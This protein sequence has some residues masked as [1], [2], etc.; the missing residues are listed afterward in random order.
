M[1]DFMA[2]VETIRE[3]LEDYDRE[4]ADLIRPIAL[5]YDGFD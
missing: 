5:L 2:R 1:V 4:L 3:Q